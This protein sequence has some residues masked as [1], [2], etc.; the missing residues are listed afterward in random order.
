MEILILD[1]ETTGFLPKGRIVEIG[2]VEL[3]LET[4]SK[5]ILFDKVIN[6]EV[7]EKEIYNTWIVENQYMTPTEILSGVK[8]D[9]IKDELQELINS[10]PSGLTAF[11]R[12]FDIKFLESYGIEFPKLLPC[13]MLVSTPICR[14]PKTGKGAAYSGYKWPK[15]E[16]AY[17]F[18]YPESEYEELHRGPDD[19]FHEADIVLALHKL[20]EFLPC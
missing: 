5:K 19:A 17:K 2:V 18:F 11:N 12:T 14:C 7:E 20:N 4:D 13:P 3:N 16:E 15:V 6:P 10:Y 9:E 1:I 8:F